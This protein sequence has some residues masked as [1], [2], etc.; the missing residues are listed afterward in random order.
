MCIDW[1]RGWNPRRCL[2]GGKV[3][4][5]CRRDVPVRVE[6]VLNCNGLPPF[7]VHNNCDTFLQFSGCSDRRKHI[8]ECVE[9]SLGQ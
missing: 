2:D 5:V 1:R 9:G 3:A 8:F 4:S 7:A 6:N